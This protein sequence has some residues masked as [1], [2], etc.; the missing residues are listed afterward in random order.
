MIGRIVSLQGKIEVRR[1]GTGPW[2][3]VSQL[4]FPLCPGDILHTGTRSRSAVVLAPET[5]VRVD[6]NS[7]MLLRPEGSEIHVEMFKDDQV[8][9]S[10]VGNACGAGYFITRFPKKFKVYTPYLNAAVEGT[11]FQVALA[12]D[13]AELSV[14]EGRVSAES[15]VSQVARL[16]LT[17]GQV[18]SAGPGEEPA[19]IKALIRP[20]DAVQWALYYPPTSEAAGDIPTD[21]M[22]LAPTERSACLTARAEGL[23]RAGRVDEAQEQIKALIELVPLSADAQALSSVIAVVKNDKAEALK[24][25]QRA[26]ELSDQSSRAWLALSYAQQ[27]H[28]ELE[29]ALGAAKRAAALAPNSALIQ[30]R[31]AELLMSLGDTRAAERAAQAAVKANP[32]ESRAHT[33]LGFVHL[34]QIDTK[35]AK[36]DFAQAIELDSTDPLPRLG[37]GLAIIREGKLEQGREQIEIAV[38]LDPTNSLIRSYVGKAYYEENSKERDTLAA[39]QFEIAKKLDPKDPTPHFY[40]AILKQTQNR[41]VEALDELQSSIQKNDNRAVYRSRLLLDNDSAARNTSRAG[42]YREL[43]FERLVVVESANALADDFANHSAHRLLAES[44]MQLPRHDI[45]R[46]SEALQAQIRQPLSL[47]LVAPLLT[48]DNLLMLKDNGP[49]I[50][51]ANEFNR[52][53][54]R[55]QARFQFDGLSGGRGTHGEQVVL[56]ALGKRVSVAASQLHYE[57][58]GFIENDSAERDIYGVFAHGQIS[59]TD[60]IQFDLK[61]SEFEVGQTFYAFEPLLLTPTTISERSTNYRLSGHHTPGSSWG[62]LIWTAIYEDRSREVESFPDGGLFTDTTAHSYATELQ[63]LNNFGPLQVLVGAGHIEEPEH[64]VLEQIDVTAKTTN[65][66]AYGRWRATGHPLSVQAGLAAER[67]EL[68]NSFF[69]SIRQQ[70]P[71][72]RKRVSPKLGLVWSP[73]PGTTLRAATFTYVRRP[74]I[75]SQTLEPTQVAGFNQFFTGFEQFYGDV[76]GT[77]SRRRGFAID[78]TISP[79]AYL[80]MEISSR[81]L[82]VP[83]IL[84]EQD[85]TWRE[86]A[87]Q[88]Y[89]YKAYKPFPA[90]WP[91]GGWRL[92]ATAQF[93]YEQLERPQILSGIEGIVDLKTTSTPLALRLINQ[94]GISGR[95]GST[96]VKQKGTFSVDVGF[97]FVPKEDDGWI[98][99]ASLEYRLPRR[100][101][102]LSVGVRNLFDQK[103]DLLEIDPLNPRVATRRFVYGRVSISF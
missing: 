5:L 2:H 103:V 102:L 85:F 40:D 44:Y 17:S 52:L 69:T 83:S 51:G 35:Q 50:L 28:F 99:D 88:A 76:R 58:E 39:S 37:N 21:C 14:F 38:A 82:R 100:L 54:S 15:L 90:H 8:P 1:A 91:L 29:K 10:V 84:L 93:E 89:L 64:F 55:N 53:F 80:G 86:K 68:E 12:C 67:F 49:S 27:A 13:R 56:G 59:S 70:E 30:A 66:Y 74:F 92:V 11:E 60:S 26:V 94:N 98:T 77:V 20:T 57:S 7:T 43:G 9:P 97:P 4:D 73:L 63:Y 16:V 42:L 71:L 96:Y 47:P 61:R 79:S 18:T 6:Q 62:D 33:V 3:A 24:L 95:V 19:P 81:R 22:G 46:V 36:Q 87:A 41:P 32:K 45:S 31:V 65:L 34:A 75:R 23:L 101:G 78:Q 72:R 25:A 48:T